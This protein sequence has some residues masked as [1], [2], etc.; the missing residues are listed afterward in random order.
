[1]R[2][3]DKDNA[4]KIS[5]TRRIRNEGIADV[6]IYPNPVNDK[7]TV[8]VNADKAT[9]GQ[10]TITDISGKIVYTRIVKLPQGNTILPIML[11]NI[12]TGSY[13]IKIHLKDDV[14]IKKFNKQ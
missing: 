2:S 13:V 10:L 4:S 11:S 5:A 14:I 1:M 12:A 3:V 9:D 8:A 7:L 6:T